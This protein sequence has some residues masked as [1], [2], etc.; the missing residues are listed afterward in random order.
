MFLDMTI[1]TGRDSLQ[2]DGHRLL[3]ASLSP[4]VADCPESDMLIL[5]GWGN[6]TYSFLLDL[7]FNGA[8]RWEK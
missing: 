4:V 7:L 2:D 8:G 6:E 1:A 5:E 3:M